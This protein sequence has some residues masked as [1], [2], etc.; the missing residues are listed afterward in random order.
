MSAGILLLFRK[1]GGRGVS[2]VSWQGH[3]AGGSAGGYGTVPVGS[4][5]GT[6]PEVVRG[7]GGT[8]P[9]GSAG[10]VHQASG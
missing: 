6:V 3:W 1:K 7:D 2:G 4:A 10:S 5:G 9:G 8:V